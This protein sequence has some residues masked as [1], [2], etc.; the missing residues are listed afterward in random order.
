MSN[1]VATR[2]ALDRDEVLRVMQQSLYPGAR[3]ESVEMVLGY[4][5]ARGL[6]PMLKPVHIVPMYVDGGMRDVPLPGIALYRIQAA[7]SG[8]Y[9]GKSEPEFG[10]DVTRTFEGTDKYNK[11]LV[12]N[13]TFPA[14]CRVTVKRGGAE[15]TAK[16]FWTENYATAGR[17]SEVPN[18]MW[19]K[20]PYGQLAKCAEAQALRMAFPELTGGDPTAEEMEGKVL[21]AEPMPPARGPVIDA[22]AEIMAER[23]P[24][25]VE[26]PDG[27]PMLAPDGSL[28]SAKSAAQW[29]Q[30]CRVAVGKLE[31]V[32]ALDEWIAAM[33]P[34]FEALTAWDA[35][36]V[37]AVRLAAGELRAQ[38]MEVGNE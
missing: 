36:A 2:P 37:Q 12:R 34:H 3:R 21:P 20:R 27:W 9:A 25:V 29:A 23:A 32:Q 6:D 22:G 15:F 30:W 7:R 17:G 26:G 5:H 18:E 31:S 11:R 24:P 16:E 10:P 33:V 19:A 8:E 14:W 38:M 4:C 35:D 1:A 13:V 28:K